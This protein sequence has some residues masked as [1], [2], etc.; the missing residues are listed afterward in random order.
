MTEL[1]FEKSC[2]GTLAPVPNEYAWG[3]TNIATSAYTLS[4]SGASNEVIATNYDL[5]YGNIAYGTTTPF[6]GIKGPVRVGIFAGTSG[7]TDRIKAGA[8]YYGIM[9]MSGNSMERSVTVGNAA[10]RSF[11]G[12]HGDGILNKNGEATVDYWPGINGNSIAT[13]ANSTYAGV[14]GVTNAAGAGSRGGCW[15]Y[16]TLSYLQVSD[17]YDAAYNYAVRNLYHCGRGV[18]TASV[19]APVIG[20]TYGGGIIFYIDGTGQHGL[21]AATTD[22]TGSIEWITGGST[23]TTANGNT[24]TAFGTGHANTNYM[25]AQTGYTGGAAKVCDDYSVT[26]DLVTYS[27]WFLPSQ[28]ELIEM[29]LQKAIIGNLASSGYWS[30]SEY[31]A[32]TAW[33][34]DIGSGGEYYATKSATSAW[35][36]A[37]RSF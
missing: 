14:T 24:S 29:Y 5:T 35:V 36:R 31:N 12:L 27:D 18:R 9:E 32:T 17:R 22:Q 11:T 26:V 4:N 33:R 2:R 19:F 8:T 13:V 30:S 34:K 1:E 23:Q 21:I 3:N 6:E 25:I 10:G 20:Q 28:N 37:I 7:N 15:L 16:P